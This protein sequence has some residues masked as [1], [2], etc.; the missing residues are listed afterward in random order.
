MTMAFSSN[1]SWVI[2]CGDYVPSSFH[3]LH[4][5]PSMFIEGCVV[6]WDMI[7]DSQSIASDL[8]HM[9]IHESVART[10]VISCGT[11]ETRDSVGA[12]CPMLENEA[13][14][15]SITSQPPH[16]ASAALAL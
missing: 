14:S 2:L 3:S 5:C 1:V 11:S 13:H 9:N 12:L 4:T 6:L 15:S 10:Y 16:L 7:S 8:L